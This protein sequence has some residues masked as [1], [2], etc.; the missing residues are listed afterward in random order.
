MKMFGAINIIYRF[1]F[2]LLYTKQRLLDG[3]V[4]VFVSKING[5]GVSSL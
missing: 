5:D 2:M 4:V 1:T 3:V